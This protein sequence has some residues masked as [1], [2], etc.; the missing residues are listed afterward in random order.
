MV[1]AGSVLTSPGPIQREMRRRITERRGAA[2]LIAGCG[3]GGAAWLAA[4]EL[5]AR[6]GG[7]RPGEAVHTSLT[8]CQPGPE[9]G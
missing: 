7:P 5:A 4:L 8:T 6:S 2:P 3:A 1:L 9:G